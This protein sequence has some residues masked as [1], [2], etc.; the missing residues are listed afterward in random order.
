MYLNQDFING[1][2]QLNPQTKLR[3]TIDAI[4]LTSEDDIKNA[5]FD[6]ESTSFIG[7]FASWKCVVSLVF[8]GIV[9]NY[10]NKQA[11]LEIGSVYGGVTTYIPIGYFYIDVDGQVTDEISNEITLTMYDAAY[12]NFKSVYVPT[13]TYP[14]T[15]RDILVD[16]CNQAGVDID[17]PFDLLLDNYVFTEQ[18][19]YPADTTLRE[20]I[21]H[22]ATANVAIA[23]INRLNKISFTCVF[24]KNNPAY[25]LGATHE[26]LSDFTHEELAEYT[27]EEIF[28]LPI[29]KQIYEIDG[30]S[31]DLLKIEKPFGPV[32]SLML[33][34][35]AEGA[36]VPFDDV[37][38]NDEASITAN[39]L[40]RIK[41]D[42]NYF[43]DNVRELIVEDLFNIVHEFVYMPFSVKIFGRPDIDPGDLLTLKDLSN[44]SYQVPITNIAQ[45]WNGG[46]MS[47][48]KTSILVQSKEPYEPSGPTK[49]LKKIA[50][51]VDKVAG[52]FYILA[53]DYNDGKLEGA[54]YV[55]NGDG[56]T[57]INGGLKIKNS[58]GDDVFYADTEGNMVLAGHIK[59]LQENEIVTV[60]IGGDFATINDALLYVQQ[61]YPQFI[62]GT[63][64]VSSA[65]IMLLSGFIMNEQI[66]VQRLNLGFVTISSEDAEVVINRS[67]L[68]VSVESG[69]TLYYPAF[70]AKENAVL[71]VINCLFNMNT[72][73]MDSN[74]VGIMCSE[75]SSA[76]VRSGCGCKM[77]STV[78]N[79]CFATECSNINADGSIFS[80]AGNAYFARLNSRINANGITTSGNNT[81][82]LAEEC[83]TININDSTI[84][85]SNAFGVQASRGSTINANSSTLSNWNFSGARSLYGSVINVT[86]SNCRKSGSDSANDISVFGGSI[87]QANSSIGGLS[88][89]ANTI[90]SNGIIFK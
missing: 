13:V 89:A 70:C 27:H 55:F 15:G 61:K 83:S 32:N 68:T 22:Y 85:N 59:M 25:E 39:G 1:I 90:T 42:N 3:L 71:P 37:V 17:I 20:M 62:S 87:I 67:A 36:E 9:P 10:R 79:G 19:N 82:A 80:G 69:G 88:Q 51:K 60:G 75:N 56:A 81:G 4:V 77:N 58:D 65:E 33:S 34:R 14:C 8:D 74:R 48:L 50:A 30:D 26:Y 54:K 18:P 46:L 44:N 31:Y 64:T 24:Y 86:N 7:D 53:G 57:F 12:F 66:L 72:T 41:I 11:F 2:N 23:F 52:E 76:T 45:D 78:T 47:E 84:T 29:D 5:S 35:S 73:G 16:I 21:M 43:T 28:L 49:D 63:N 40:F 6:H 38:I